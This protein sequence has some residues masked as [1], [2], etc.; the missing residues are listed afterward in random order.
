MIVYEDKFEKYVNYVCGEGGGRKV[1]I[2]EYK[3]IGY[4]DNS[5][6]LLSLLKKIIFLGVTLG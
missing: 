5:A 1:G 2:I 6:C 4:S 3:L